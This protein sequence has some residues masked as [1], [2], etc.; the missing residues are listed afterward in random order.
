MTIGQWQ[1]APLP[2]NSVNHL[3]MALPDDALDGLYHGPLEEF[4]SAR[5]ELAK[6]LRSDGEAAAADEVKALRKPSRAAWLV[7]QLGV[8]KP[9]EVGELLEVGEEL[10]A[11]Q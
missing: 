4:T 9:K 2:L 8:R 6:S 5:N 10:R 11:A 7:N 3:P 1:G